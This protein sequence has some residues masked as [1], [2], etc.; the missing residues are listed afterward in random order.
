LS[1]VNSASLQEILKK[2]LSNV[3]KEDYPLYA[4]I[5]V[6]GPV[7]N[8]EI[9]SLTNIPQ[10]PRFSGEELAKEFGFKKCVLLKKAI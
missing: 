7:N 8:N 4:V 10:W 5:G 3:K 1:S 9:I 2:Y 6:A